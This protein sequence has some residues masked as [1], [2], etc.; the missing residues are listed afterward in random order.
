MNSQKSNIK[1][2]ILVFIALAI[3]TVLEL[4]ATEMGADL[5]FLKALSLT[6]LAVLKAAMVAYWFMHIEHERPWLTFI[7]LVPIS[8]VLF[9][10]VV[11]LDSIYRAREFF[12][13][14]KM[15]TAGLI[16]VLL[17]A[18]VIL[19]SFIYIKDKKR[20]GK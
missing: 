8:A 17:L 14:F 7:A 3:L 10:V 6:L 16:A 5:Y 13:Q 1:K 2:Y 20:H 11:A 4:A 15:P 18:L 12:E 19:K 9:T